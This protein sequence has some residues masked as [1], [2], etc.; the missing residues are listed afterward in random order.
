[1][2]WWLVGQCL[3]LKITGLG[4]V[5]W[6]DFNLLGWT[7]FFAGGLCVVAHHFLPR[8]QGLC[9]VVKG[10][11]PFG[12]ELWLTI[13]DGPDP[14]DTPQILDLL[15]EY[16]AKATFFMIGSNAQKHP[17]LVIEVIRRGHTVGNHTHTHPLKCFW[18][19]GRKRVCLELDTS[20]AVLRGAGAEVRLFRAPVGIKNVFLKR[21]LAERGLRCVAWTIRS[22]DT[23]ASKQDTVIKRVLD[24]AKPGAIILM[25][26]GKSVA[27]ALR[28]ESLR[29]VICL[30][31]FVAPEEAVFSE[32]M[33]SI[34]SSIWLRV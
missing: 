4:L 7:I 5:F 16:G 26:E 31:Y 11:K 14:V 3:F 18:C 27:K 29:S 6:T 21:C 22:G 20:L 12:R 30:K 34:W 13:D 17:E 9:D 19:A 8:S 10:F 1:M 32:M 15:D 25:H 24:E 28:I 33:G 23:L 2:K